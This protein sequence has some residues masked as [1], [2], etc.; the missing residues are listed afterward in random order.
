MTNW[1]SDNEREIQDIPDSSTPEQTSTQDNYNIH[2]RSLFEQVLHNAQH[3]AYDANI[4]RYVDRDTVDEGR[5]NV[6]LHLLYVEQLKHSE[7]EKRRLV[8]ET[9]EKSIKRGQLSHLNHKSDEP[10]PDD[11]RLPC[12]L[13]NQEYF[14]SQLYIITNKRAATWFEDHNVTIDPLDRRFHRNYC[15]EEARVCLFCYQFFDDGSVI[16]ASTSNIAMWAEIDEALMNSPLKIPISEVESSRPPLASAGSSS[17]TTHLRPLS[18]IAV[19]TALFKL[20]Q[21]HDMTQLGLRY[22]RIEA[23]GIEK[24]GMLDQERFGR[25]LRDKYTTVRSCFGCL[26]ACLVDRLIDCID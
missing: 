7:G 9:R 19:D 22:Q 6:K 24:G 15:H 14:K 2:S 26:L 1:I 5:E 16:D 4:G 11:K 25:F 10:M 21:K 18:A 12:I 20:K 3:K 17:S 8:R 13:C 23:H